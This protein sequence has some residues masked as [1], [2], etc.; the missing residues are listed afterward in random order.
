MNFNIG[1]TIYS[2]LNAEFDGKVKVYPLINTDENAKMPFICY[3]RSSYLPEYTKNLYSLI[4]TY[5]YQISVV[6]D[7]YKE[8]IG[9][10]DRVINALMALTGTAVDGKSIQS[11]EVVNAEETVTEDVLFVQS[12]DFDIKITK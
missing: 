7:V 5:H 3:R 6:S 1:D 12:L 4:D 2:T 11:F 10:A 8:G 9:I